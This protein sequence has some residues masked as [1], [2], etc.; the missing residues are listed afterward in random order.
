MGRPAASMIG[1]LAEDAWP[2]VAMLLQYSDA[3]AT[4]YVEFSIGEGNERRTYDV[5][6]GPVRG[7]GGTLVGRLEE[8]QQQLIQS[9][10]LAAIG[11][12]VSG[13]AHELNNPL[14]VVMGYTEMLRGGIAKPE[15]LDRI[16]ESL[17]SETR[18]AIDIVQGLLTFSR[19]S[20]PYRE[21]I[22]INEVVHRSLKLWSVQPGANDV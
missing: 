13:V 18:R 3:N 12:L 9:E 21:N 8:T 16:L 14:T 19:P 10:K 22:S 5:A 1:R 20:P 2:E 17:N 11:Q 15:D 6:F 4:T 7:D